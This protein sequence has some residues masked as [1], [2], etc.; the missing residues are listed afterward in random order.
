MIKLPFLVV[1]MTIACVLSYAN[2]V[3]IFPIVIRYAEIF[4]NYICYHTIE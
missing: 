2:Y 3:L 4:F 1:T